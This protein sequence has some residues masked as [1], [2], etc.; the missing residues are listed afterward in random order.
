MVDAESAPFTS[1]QMQ[2]LSVMMFD[3]MASQLLPK[4]FDE[5]TTFCTTDLLPKMKDDFSSAAE[6]ILQQTKQEL[7]ERTFKSQCSKQDA[8][9]FMTDNKESFNKYEALRDSAFWSA[10]R[11]YELTKLYQE[12]LDENPVYVPR[13]FRRDKYHVVSADELSIL[14]QREVNDLKSEIDLFRLREE[15]N[16]KKIELQDDL[17][18]I[19]VNEKVQNP[20]LKEEILRTWNQNNREEMERV[21]EVWKKKISGMKKGYVKDKEF[22]QR[23]N[24]KR[25]KEQSSDTTRRNQSDNEVR[26]TEGASRNP[27]VITIEPDE[28][29]GEEENVPNDE[30]TGDTSAPVVAEDNSQ[31]SQDI[32]GNTTAASATPVEPTQ[33]VETDERS[34][35][36]NPEVT[37]VMD[38]EGVD[39]DDDFSDVEAPSQILFDNT[40]D[41]NNVRTLAQ[42]DGTSD[43]EE[44]DD[45]DTTTDSAEQ[46]F[47]DGRNVRKKPKPQKTRRSYSPQKIEQRR[48]SRLR[49]STSRATTSQ[50]H[51]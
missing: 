17:V 3:Q 51:R 10:T 50:Q 37:S 7:R 46:I 14:K 25:V 32:P 1:V 26:D 22:I 20:Y 40:Q 43:E 44:D 28:E 6:T 2:Q 11:Y 23:H 27:E 15:R 33:P 12:C 24:V 45:D 36:N 19:L 29:E 48:S 21:N 41:R 47:R 31:R 8:M 30:N 42:F 18:A 49:S 34:D 39:S 38:L 5:M 16:R 4:L 9:K 35:E 13:K